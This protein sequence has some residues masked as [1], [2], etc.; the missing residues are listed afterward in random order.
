MSK[1]TGEAATNKAQELVR[2]QLAD[3]KTEAFVDDGMLFLTAT[4][5]RDGEE[6]AASHAY[7]LDSMRPEELATAAR[8]VA[9]RVL[10]QLQS[11]D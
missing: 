3:A 10:Q 5:E 9:N 6:L 7:T 1:K 8:D 2:A 11:R 4:I